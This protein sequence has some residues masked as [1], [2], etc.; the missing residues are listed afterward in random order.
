MENVVICF[1]NATIMEWIRDWELDYIF[2]YL[3]ITAE[4]KQYI[5]E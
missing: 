5:L 2:F 3:L 4:V 1:L